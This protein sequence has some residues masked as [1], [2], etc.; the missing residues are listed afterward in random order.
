[1]K[2]KLLWLPM[3]LVAALFLASCSSSDDDLQGTYIY[4]G[5][6]FGGNFSITIESD[7]SFTFY[8]GLLSSYIG[9]GQCQIKHNVLTINDGN[10]SNR[11]KMLD[12]ELV[13]V[14]EGSTNF[15]Y[16]DLKNGDKFIKTDSAE[17]IYINA[18]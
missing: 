9:H 14:E 15:M 13:F 8:E 12:N 16:V 17:G 2:I 10:L 11:F 5:E 4:D 7:G 18:Q 6:G 3:V 1:M